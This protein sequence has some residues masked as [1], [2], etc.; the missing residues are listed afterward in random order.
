LKKTPGNEIL[1]NPGKEIAALKRALA[2]AHQ[3]EAAAAEVLKTIS[4][5]SFDLQTVL[6]ALIESAA[7]L[8]EAEAAAIARQF[9]SVYKPVATYGQAGDDKAFSA[10]TTIR[11]TRGSA[12][13]RAVID[14]R[15]AHIADVLADPEYDSWENQRP[16]GFRTILAVPLLR[17]RVPIGVIIL[18]RK[19]VRPFTD[20]QI[21]LVSTFADQ[22][23]IATEN[24]RLFDEV[25]A[26]TKE[27]IE[28]L[29]Q[30]TATSEVLQVISSSPGELEQVFQAMLASATRICEAK[31]GSLYLYDGENYRTGA[32]HNAPL[33]LVELRQREPVFRVAAGTG[34]GRA[35]STKQGG[36]HS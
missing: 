20:K 27:L 28:S 12:L 11:P 15:A 35:A 5:S 17:E 30:Q 14:C 10:L 16:L 24:V 1:A 13:G 34:L 19:V 26:R 31:F 18:I 3:R 22:A 21:D 36:S 8:C 6:E 23:V 4:R 9:D 32:L 2:E 29:E 25:Q 7:K 33:A